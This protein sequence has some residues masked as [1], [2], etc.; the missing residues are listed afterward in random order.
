MK[1][2]W[3]KIDRPKSF[4]AENSGIGQQSMI[5]ASPI[6]NYLEHRRLSRTIAP[7]NIENN[8]SEMAARKSEENGNAQFS[9]DYFAEINDWVKILG[10]EQSKEVI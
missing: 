4:L 1:L 5:S 7:V 6:R 3:A 8:G 10:I 9:K 2:R